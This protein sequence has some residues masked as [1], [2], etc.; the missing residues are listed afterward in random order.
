MDDCMQLCPHTFKHVASE[1]CRD[2]KRS[3]GVITPAAT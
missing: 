2:Y 1:S 3:E